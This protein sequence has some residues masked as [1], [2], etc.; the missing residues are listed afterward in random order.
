MIMRT[1]CWELEPET[2]RKVI[3]L[4]SFQGWHSIQIGIHFDLKMINFEL[5]LPF[6]FIRIGKESAFKTCICKEASED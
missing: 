4:F 2:K 5:H 1:R 6:C 3:V